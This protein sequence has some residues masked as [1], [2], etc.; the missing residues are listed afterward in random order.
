MSSGRGTVLSVSSTQREIIPEDLEAA[1]AKNNFQISKILSK[2][3]PFSAVVFFN[4]DEES[5]R[6]LNSRIDYKG[7]VLSVSLADPKKER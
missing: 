2:S 1:F 4:N 6:A 3:T 7:E 5:Y